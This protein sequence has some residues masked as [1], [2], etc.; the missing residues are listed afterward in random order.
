M[1]ANTSKLTHRKKN[2]ITFDGLLDSM[3][4]F[5]QRCRE[6]DAMIRRL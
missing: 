6:A 3:R 5:A 1:A 4:R 2:Q